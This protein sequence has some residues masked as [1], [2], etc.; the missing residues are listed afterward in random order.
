MKNATLLTTIIFVMSFSVYGLS[1]VNNVD[2]ISD[3]KDFYVDIVNGSND[4]TGTSIDKAWRTITYA[5]AIVKYRYYL[6]GTITIHAAPGEYSYY[7]GEIFP[8]RLSSN[9]N[10]IGASPDSSIINAMDRDPDY[11]GFNPIENNDVIIGC[12]N[13]ENVLIKG[14]TIEDGNIGID[15]VNSSVWIDSC[16]IQ[17]I[18]YSIPE[19]ISVFASSY[20]LFLSDSNS[21]ITNCELS[22]MGGESGDRTYAVY[23]WNSSPLFVNCL[24]ADNDP[25]IG[26]MI[27]SEFGSKPK[28]VNCTIANN[29]KN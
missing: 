26:S 14:F 5:L 1:A 4:N 10:L 22:S 27:L 20:G 13:V 3:S 8:L 23:C 19:W 2:I 11:T 24:I 17:N 12:Y 6:H 28:F 21:K 25:G 9:V 29:T 7:N 18:Y 16:K 15:C